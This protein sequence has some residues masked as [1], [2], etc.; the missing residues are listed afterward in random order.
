M[1][2]MDQTQELITSS[3][4]SP[5][6]KILTLM[7]LSICVLAAIARIATKLSM[8]GKLR[9]D[10]CLT[11]ISAVSTCYF[12]HPVPQQNTNFLLQLFA[13]GQS[14]AVIIQCGNG[15][16]RHIDALSENHISA[17]LKVEISGAPSLRCL[18]DKSF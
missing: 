11:T 3:D 7:F 9:W 5:L 2:I 10:D 4:K 18:T 15:F 13:I 16:G 1:T 8:V 17:V 14:V 6:V 12:T